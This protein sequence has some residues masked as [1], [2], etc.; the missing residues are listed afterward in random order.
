[1]N[2][3]FN[4]GDILTCAANHFKVALL[5]SLFNEV[6]AQLALRCA[7]LFLCAVLPCLLLLCAKEENPVS[8]IAA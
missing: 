2:R 5:G 3:Y 4:K 7:F 6:S 1:M 8:A